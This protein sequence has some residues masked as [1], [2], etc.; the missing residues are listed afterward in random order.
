[1]V[2]SLLGMS[3]SVYDTAVGETE[4]EGQRPL[5]ADGRQALRR[6]RRRSSSRRSL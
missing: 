1:M 2:S 5:H 4:R 3:P 6:C